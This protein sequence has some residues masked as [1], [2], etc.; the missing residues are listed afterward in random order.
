MWEF[1]GSDTVR[2][3]VYLAAAAALAVVGFYVVLKVRAS[4]QD[5]PP[6]TSELISKFR[7]LHSR[8]GLSDEEYRTVKSK[9]GAQ[10]QGELK[11]KETE[12]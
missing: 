8:G 11:A 12:K 2:L 1:L 5:D 4:L 3:V 6:E 9:L 7:E 10:L